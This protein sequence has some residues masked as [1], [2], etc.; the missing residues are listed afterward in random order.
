[1]KDDLPYFTHDNDARNHAKM[2]AL[3]ARFGWTGYGQFWALNEM[4]AGSPG[5]RL[6][7][8]RKVVR[9]AVACELGMTTD[10]LEDLLAF[11]ADP[12]ECGLID[13]DSGIVTTDRTQEDYSRTE[14]GRKAS[15]QRYERKKRPTAEKSQFSP[16]NSYST[17]SILAR[18]TIENRI[19]EN[20]IEERKKEERSA[21]TLHVFS[22]PEF[23]N[24]SKPEDRSGGAGSR[25]ETLRQY[26]N[27]KTNLPR[28]RHLPTSMPP[29]QAG[30]ALRTLGAYTD[31]EIRKAI[32]NYAQISGSV[33]HEAFPRFAGFPGFL[34]SG[35]ESYS[36][37]AQPHI[38]CALDNHEESAQ[39]ILT[40]VRAK[41][42][43]R[44]G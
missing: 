29:E 34:K 22:L 24:V 3:R 23:P 2:K 37:E 9:A 14:S 32:D 26:W 36:D 12:D 35:P 1:M 19:E 7:I 20:R 33:E 21:E 40:R 27:A 28:Y 18:E 5:A 42:A 30:P 25:L 8:S 10:A 4:I 38:R 11:L 41:E 17:V 16:E 15:K 44:A 6:D 43:A 39:D 31:E 13:Y